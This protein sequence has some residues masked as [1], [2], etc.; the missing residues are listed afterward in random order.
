MAL[1]SLGL[2]TPSLDSQLNT[3]TIW[4][5]SSGSFDLE[6]KGQSFSTKR[7]PWTSG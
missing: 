6:I 1:P 4:A 5:E 3:D 7:V 2:M